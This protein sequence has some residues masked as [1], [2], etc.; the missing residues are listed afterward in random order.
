MREKVPFI[1]DEKT[2]RL[3]DSFTFETALGNLD[4][5][6]TPS[7]T[8]GYDDLRAHAEEVDLGDGLR[9]WF[10]SLEDLI[11]MKQ[12]S[13]R[14]KDLIELEVLRAVLDERRNEP[15]P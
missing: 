12:A 8:Q 2:F 6:G 3:G 7:G 15:K 14:R 9:V 10:T 5:L 1:L 4:C 11:R 13:A